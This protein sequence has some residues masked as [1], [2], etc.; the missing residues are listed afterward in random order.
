[1]PPSIPPLHRQVPPFVMLIAAHCGVNNAVFYQ[2]HFP[3]AFQLPDQ[4]TLKVDLVSES[5]P[6]WWGGGPGSEQHGINHIAYFANQGGTHDDVIY[7]HNSMGRSWFI[8]A[9]PTTL[10]SSQG[11]QQRGGIRSPTPTSTF[12]AFTGCP[13]CGY[14]IR[15]FAKKLSEAPLVT[16]QV[17]SQLPT[18][19]VSHPLFLNALGVGGTNVLLPTGLSLVLPSCYSDSSMEASIL[20]SRGHY[21]LPPRDQPL[22]S[23][24][25]GGEVGDSAGGEAD[26]SPSQ[27]SYDWDSDV[28]GGAG[29]EDGKEGSGR[30]GEGGQVEGG[31]LPRRWGDINEPWEDI[32][33]P[34]YLKVQRMK[35]LALMRK[36]ARAKKWRDLV[37]TEVES[38]TADSDSGETE[39]PTS[40]SPPPA[41]N[42]KCEVAMMDVTA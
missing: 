15:M 26:V 35:R 21:L 42:L 23:I 25:E 24:G 6:L 27:K 12:Y 34:V 19:S 37:D 39:W 16:Y 40:P 7:L 30:G 4:S 11:W 2:T 31:V 5:L 28:D 38:F 22:P 41:K 18:G 13:M 33:F 1:M 29:A 9:F 8:A 14:W 36:E 10:Y 3:H 32:R 20:F 17:A